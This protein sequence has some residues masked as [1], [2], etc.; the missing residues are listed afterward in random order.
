MNL[1]HGIRV[2]VAHLPANFPSTSHLQPVDIY[3][4]LVQLE[5]NPMSVVFNFVLLA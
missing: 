4:F 3:P 2:I 5:R 1:M